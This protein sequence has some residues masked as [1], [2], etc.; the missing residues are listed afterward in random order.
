MS[1]GAMTYTRD[2]GD[3]RFPPASGT[4]AMAVTETGAS[5]RSPNLNPRSS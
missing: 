1:L 5:G 3:A 2:E 4:G